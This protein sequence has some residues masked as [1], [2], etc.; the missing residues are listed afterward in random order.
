MYELAL[1]P[2]QRRWFD[3]GYAR[4]VVAFTR[5][6]S[7]FPPWVL[8]L[9]AR[10]VRG[11]TR[12]SSQLSTGGDGGF[13]GRP[14]HQEQVFA[15]RGSLHLHPRPRSVCEVSRKYPL[16]LHGRWVRWDLGCLWPLSVTHRGDAP[17]VIPITQR[18]FMEGAK[19]HGILKA[20]ADQGTLGSD[21][22]AY[23]T[24]PSI[25]DGGNSL[26][27]DP[28]PSFTGLA[29]WKSGVPRECTMAVHSHTAFDF[30]R[31]MYNNV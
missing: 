5:A 21:W 2:Q 1:F 15:R 24:I 19:D 16:P 22:C 12:G 7:S 9:E 13:Q 10:G 6:L 14:Y 25:Q 30:Y 3:F 27:V 26:L 29:F 31:T 4:L 28:H 18:D 23:R 20:A 17:R 8:C 11:E